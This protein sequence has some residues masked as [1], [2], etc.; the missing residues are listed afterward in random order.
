MQIGCHASVWTGEFDDAGLKLAIDK[1]R[2]AGFDLIEIPLMD[3]DKAD[4]AA[5]RRVLDSAG[6][7]TTASL[8]LSEHTD[9]SSEDPEVVAAGEALLHSCLEFLSDVGGTHLVGVIYSAM[10]KYMTPA[11]DLNRQHSIEAIGRLTTRAAELG[12]QVGVEVVNRYESNVL[13]TSRQ[14]VRYVEDADVENLVVHLD[15]YHMNI[16]EPDMF[17]PVLDAGC[18]LG[19]VHIG[20]SHRGY[21]GSGT[22]DFDSFFRAL[23]T[24]GY[25]GPVVFE[26]FSSAVVHP[27]LSNMLGIWRNLWADGDD[28]GRHANSYIRNQLATVAS[29]QMH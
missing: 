11:T 10:R 20:E 14:A 27:D 5:V 12:V 24:I 9:I 8:G 17:T 23:A 3:P 6:L 19:Y 29:I 25:D 28:L 16:E 13:N 15:T 21:L 18:R 26:S 4:P 1:T 22:V 7:A 2:A